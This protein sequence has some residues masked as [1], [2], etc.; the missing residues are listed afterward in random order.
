MSN[1]MQLFHKFVP[2]L[3]IIYILDIVYVHR[4]GI[5]IILKHYISHIHKIYHI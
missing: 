4:H 1:S 3:Y 2:K 5:C